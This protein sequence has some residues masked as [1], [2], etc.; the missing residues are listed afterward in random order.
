MIADHPY[1]VL[2]IETT[3]L[4]PGHHEIIEVSTIRVARGQC[5]EKTWLLRPI[6]SD[7]VDPRA[8]SV[9]GWAPDRWAS[10]PHPLSPIGLS[11]YAEIVQELK[12]SFVVGHNVGFDLAFLRQ[13][14]ETH[15]YASNARKLQRQLRRPAI[16]GEIDTIAIAW[17]N[18]GCEVSRL[19]LDV[20]R[21][22][23]PAIR[24]AGH[25]HTSLGDCRAVLALLGVCG[26]FAPLE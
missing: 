16:L 4:K 12:G 11:R 18:L 21:D 9:N 15:K 10:H 24:S 20:L 6:H 23:Y 25:A 7:R 13:H 22:R 19:S 2:D 17:L 26:G 3:G 8:L 14:L 1:T 5:S